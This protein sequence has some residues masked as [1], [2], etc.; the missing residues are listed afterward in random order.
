MSITLNVNSPCKFES[1][2]SLQTWTTNIIKLVFYAVFI[3]TVESHFTKRRV[4]LLLLFVCVFVCSLL[5]LFLIS[6]LVG[7]DKPISQ[8]HLL[9][10][11]RC[12]L[13]DDSILEIQTKVDKRAYFNLGTDQSMRVCEAMSSYRVNGVQARG[14][15]RTMF[16]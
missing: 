2:H 13:I 5:S 6:A 14:F 16:R 9:N 1:W 10:Q 15:C 8:R 7:E 3:L 4:Q 12:F 11:I